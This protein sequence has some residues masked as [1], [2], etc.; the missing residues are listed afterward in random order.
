GR[1][2]TGGAAQVAEGATL[3]RGAGPG[4]WGIP[5]ERGRGDDPVPAF[6]LGEA[7][8]VGGALNDRVEVGGDLT[9]DGTLN[10]TTPVG[11]FDAGV[12][13][14][15]NYAGTLTDNG[16][17]PG[18]L[19]PGAN[20]FVQTAVA[21]QASLV[22]TAG[23]GLNFGDGA[24]GTAND[25]RVEGGDGVWRLS[26]DDWTSAAGSLNGPYLNGAFAVFT[27]AAGT[28]TIDDAD[29][30]VTAAGLQFAV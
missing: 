8:V 12:Y 27:G 23:A 28:V 21:H 4:P 19:P 5:G 6:E 24:A 30:A 3:A 10:V 9:L 22:N 13:R 1:R 26:G 14:L 15:F 18:S 17:E 29:G 2:A 11:S 25:G 20:A 7:D 16:L